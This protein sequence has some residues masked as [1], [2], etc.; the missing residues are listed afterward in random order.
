MRMYIYIYMCVCV[1]M[2]ICIY[3]KFHHI[4]LVLCVFFSSPRL[5]QYPIPP[6]A[7]AELDAAK[8]TV[9]MCLALTRNTRW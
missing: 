6:P 7:F 8:V 4:L 3:I 1:Y 2:Y 9:E 5:S